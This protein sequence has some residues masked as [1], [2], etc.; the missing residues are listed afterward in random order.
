[1][2]ICCAAPNC[3][4]RQGKGE[5]GAIS[6][7]RFPLK[8]SAR[9]YLWT[10]AIQ[11]GDWTPG[12]YSFLCSEHFSEDSFVPRMPDQHPLLR[13]DAVPSLF[14]GGK[15]VKRKGAFEPQILRLGKRKHLRKKISPYSLEDKGLLVSPSGDFVGKSDACNKTDA[16]DPGH[17]LRRCSHH[18]AS[19]FIFTLHSYSRSS[20]MTFS[21]NSDSSLHQLEEGTNH[22]NDLHLQEKDRPSSSP[23]YGSEDIL[24]TVGG[25]PTSFG[26]NNTA[27]ASIAPVSSS[28][29]SSEVFESPVYGVQ[30]TIPEETTT[31]QTNQCD[32]QEL[33]AGFRE[34]EPRSALSGH[35]ARGTPP[36]NPAVASLAWMLGTWVSDPPGEGE[37]PSIPCFRY[38]E[39]AVVSHV[40]QP[41][42]NFTFCAS[43][44]ETGKA[45]HR[46]CGFIRVK[47]GT[48]QVAFICAQ[49]TGV[50][51][52]EEGEVQGEQLT[53]TSQSLSRISFAKEPHVQQISRTFRLTAEGR[54]EQTVS[55]ATSTQVMAPHLRVTYK[56][57]T[58]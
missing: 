6:F 16:R 34:E 54:L 10:A 41:M 49:N 23:D 27:L 50:V 57:V 42:L 22:P 40:G 11:R 2:V 37:F 32:N 33:T 26:G 38:M 47:P 58:S 48:N 19:K 14:R 36:L 4:N 13:P 21:Q 12:P 28:V 25:S 35:K 46:E 56:K 30:D 3:T 43:N 44:P 52:V 20:A 45:M 29:C 8:D 31:S 5:R 39:E 55:M 24:F 18:I 51:E 53:L 15:E 17:S 1:M 9:L 7:H